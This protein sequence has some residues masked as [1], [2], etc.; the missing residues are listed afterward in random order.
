M[1]GDN[2]VHLKGNNPEI[3]LK[4]NFFSLDTTGDLL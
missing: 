4:I 1:F 2:V 3:P